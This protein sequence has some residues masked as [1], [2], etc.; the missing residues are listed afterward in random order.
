MEEREEVIKNR[1]LEVDEVNLQFITQGDN[2]A[3]PDPSPISFERFIGEASVY[4]PMAGQ[5]LMNLDTTTGFA[6]GSI[7][8]ALLIILFVVPVLL[9]SDEKEAQ[10]AAGKKPINVKQTGRKQTGKKPIRKLP[11]FLD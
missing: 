7:L 6:V 8:L 3:T 4:V 10:A 1:I 9:K 2:N 11:D 5:I